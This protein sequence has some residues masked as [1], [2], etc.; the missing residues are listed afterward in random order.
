MHRGS[1]ESNLDDNVTHL[2]NHSQGSSSAA[3]SGLFQP[4]SFACDRIL[5]VYSRGVLGVTI[6]IRC[7]CLSLIALLRRSNDIVQVLQS[8]LHRLSVSSI[9]PGVLSGL[10]IFQMSKVRYSEEDPSETA[11]HTCITTWKELT[12]RRMTAGP[13]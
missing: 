11:F 2:N 3:L 13:L 9:S 6:V 10:I 7:L 4:E 5:A 12:L 8:R 1:T